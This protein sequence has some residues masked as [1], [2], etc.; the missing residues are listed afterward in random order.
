MR[1]R[2]LALA[3]LIVGML[4]LLLFPPFEQLSLQPRV[5]DLRGDHVLLGHAAR[6]AVVGGGRRVVDVDVFASS[7]GGRVPAAAVGRLVVHRVATTN[8]LT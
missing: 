3:L 1:R 4:L 7:G 2:T 8:V 6:A 5:L